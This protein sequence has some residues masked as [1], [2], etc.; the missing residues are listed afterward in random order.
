MADEVLRMEHIT[1]IYSNGFIANQDVT[2]EI[3]RAHV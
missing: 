2:F 1:K 3:G